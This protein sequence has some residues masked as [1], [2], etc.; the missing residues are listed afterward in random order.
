MSLLRC[1]VTL[2][3]MGLSR[4]A[5]ALAGLRQL[6]PVLGT[7]LPPVGTHPSAR[8]SAF[9]HGMRISAN[10]PPVSAARDVQGYP[11]LPPCGVGSTPLASLRPQRPERVS[12]L[13]WDLQVQ[14][15]WDHGQGFS[16]QER[17]WV[18][19]PN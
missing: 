2:E 4:G 12:P 1:M 10:L 5:G 14:G 13:S 18:P 15:L 16:I 6:H 19:K 17:S 11:S 9:A 7:F 8:D 3:V